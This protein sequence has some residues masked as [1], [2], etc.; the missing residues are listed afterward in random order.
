MMPYKQIIIHKILTYNNIFQGAMP[1]IRFEQC[2]Q[3]RPAPSFNNFPTDPIVINS[4]NQRQYIVFMIRFPC[5]FLRNEVFQALSFKLFLV[6]HK[7]I[8]AV[9]HIAL[10]CALGEN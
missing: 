7:I 3:Y 5:Y 10:Q 1:N 9:K 2:T 4:L 8:S 6:S